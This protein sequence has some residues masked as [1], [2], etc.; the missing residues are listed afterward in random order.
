MLEKLAADVLAATT[1][2]LE[3]SRLPQWLT[4]IIAEHHWS[5]R[6]VQSCA[7]FITETV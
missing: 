4:G 6:L 1:S 2:G 3:E 5:E 7:I